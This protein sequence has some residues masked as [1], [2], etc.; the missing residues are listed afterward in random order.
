MNTT[1][2]AGE[3]FSRVPKIAQAFEKAFPEMK[4]LNILNNNRELAYQS[5]FHSHIHLVPR[6]SKEDDFSH[7][8]WQPS[9]QL[10]TRRTKS[11][12]KKQF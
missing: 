3:V 4:G 2:L 8:L 5:V 12:S 7:P 10:W 9:G 6:Y 1:E 11:Y